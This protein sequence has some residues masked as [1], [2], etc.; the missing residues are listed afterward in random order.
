MSSSASAPF[1]T[2][3][4]Y[5]IAHDVWQAKT[6]PQSLI[7][8]A[9]STDVS[10]ESTSKIGTVLTVNAGVISGT[11]RTLV[12]MGQAMVPSRYRNYRLYITGGTGVGQNKRIVNYQ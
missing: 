8:S 5:D 6:V 11:A 2:L 7:L 10:T 12:D 1:M 3:Q 9:L 4:Y